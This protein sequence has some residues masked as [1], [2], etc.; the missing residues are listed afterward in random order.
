MFR[1]AAMQN[2]LF[3]DLKFSLE[4][5]LDHIF[6]PLAKLGKGNSSNDLIGK[7]E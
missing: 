4:P 6:Y 5:F 2:A 3:A 7:G 1:G